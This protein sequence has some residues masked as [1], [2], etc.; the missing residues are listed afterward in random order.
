LGADRGGNSC[1]TCLHEQANQRQ[2]GRILRRHGC[3]VWPSGPRVSRAARLRARAARLSSGRRGPQ[4]RVCDRSGRLAADLAGW[5]RSFAMST[6]RS[7][8]QGRIQRPQRQLLWG[9]PGLS[10]ALRN[11]VSLQLEIAA[12]SFG[13]ERVKLSFP[14]GDFGSCR[15]AAHGSLRGLYGRSRRGKRLQEESSRESPEIRGKGGNI[16]LRRSAVEAD[17]HR[18]RRTDRCCVS[19]C[20]GVCCYCG[21]GCVA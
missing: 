7:T 9:K 1:R 2:H 19:E 20:V 15:R 3:A 10:R 8:F 11:S 6:T 17:R 4:L 16:Q 14:P 5:I 13:S 12:V 21:V 18:W